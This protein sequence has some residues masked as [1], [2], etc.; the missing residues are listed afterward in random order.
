MPPKRSFVPSVAQSFVKDFLGGSSP[1][2][3]LILFHKL[4]AGKTC[5]AIG[6]AESVTRAKKIIV[7]L[8]ASLESNFTSEIEKC[9]TPDDSRYTFIHYNGLTIDKVSSFPEDMFDDSVIIIDEVHN[10]TKSVVH[11]DSRIYRVLFRLISQARNSKVI[12]MTGTPMVNDAAE[13]S[14]LITLVK[15]FATRHYLEFPNLHEMNLERIQQYLA[16][17]HPCI[18]KCG[19]NLS[20]KEI[21]VEMLP[22]NLRYVDPKKKD[23]VI[24]RH[25][26]DADNLQL[27]GYFGAKKISVRKVAPIVLGKESFEEKYIDRKRRTCK[28]DQEADFMTRASMCVSY[29]QPDITGL[30]P[31]VTQTAVVRCPMSDIQFDRYVVARQKE[32]AM[33]RRR[34]QQSEEDAPSVYRT[35]SRRICN[36]CLPMGVHTLRQAKSRI[37]TE[38]Q[39]MSPK[40]R[41]LVDSLLSKRSGP[42]LIY[43]SFRNVMEG[44]PAIMASLEE[45]GYEKFDVTVN[46]QGVFSTTTLTPNKKRFTIF[47]STKPEDVM[48]QILYVFNNDF[49]KVSDSIKADL[50]ESPDNR[51]GDIIDVIMISESGSEGI[52]LRNVRQVHVVEPYWQRVRIQQVIG[53][54]VRAYSHHDLPENERTVDVF[55]YISTMTA[56]QSKRL[57]VLLRRND[58]SKTTD[59]YLLELSLHKGQ[60][61]DSFVELLKRV[62]VDCR[63]LPPARDCF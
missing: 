20:A 3:G 43:S 25:P 11:G 40:Y 62:A 35:Y 56:E 16:V 38:L 63:V 48:K 22:D 28:H 13:I 59:Q 57:P 61:I 52:S 17:Q 36:F 21:W 39:D 51:N 49:E 15:G 18:V 29:Y 5:A 12:A 2:R 8:A 34:K 27:L 58:K 37:A 14:Y 4:G 32:A 7:L 42:A 41:S 45:H 44:L 55:L 46:K 31:T 33:E 1:H 10:I 50:G 54:A 19:F 60:I 26:S 30:Y 9:G 6:I 24:D 23:A 53:R 47:D